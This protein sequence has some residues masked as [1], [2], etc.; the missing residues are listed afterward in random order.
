MLWWSDVLLL[1]KPNSFSHIQE[2]GVSDSS[3]HELRTY[4]I[5]LSGIL[6]GWGLTKSPENKTMTYIQYTL[7]EKPDKCKSEEEED[8]Q[9]KLIRGSVP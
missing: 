6:V 9:F 5:Y 4:Q 7:G 8:L 2:S 1:T 3:Y